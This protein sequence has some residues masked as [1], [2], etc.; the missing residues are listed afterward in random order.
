MSKNKIYNS[1]IILPLKEGYSKND[2]G[3]VSVWV[4]SYLSYTKDKK[5][6]IFCKKNSNNKYLSKNVKPINVNSK[7]YTNFNY[8]KNI[9]DE[10]KKKS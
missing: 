3:A 2:F 9:C 5:I 7:L 4:N 8:I 10:I 1:G 6:I